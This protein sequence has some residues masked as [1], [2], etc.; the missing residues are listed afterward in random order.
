[1]LVNDSPVIALRSAAFGYADR[2]VVHD[3]SLT[4]RPGETI[5]IVGANG[6]GKSTL[7]KGLLGL[8]DQ[9]GG[10]V[11]LFGTPLASF[12]DRSL[13]GYVPQR[14]TLSTSVA[15]T[16]QEV[17]AIGRLPH[18][19]LLARLRPVDRQIIASSLEV[20]G[21]E[22]H[23]REEVS[24]LSGGQQ[25]RVLVARALA[26][27]PRVLVMDEPTA[28]V[29]LTN[30]RLLTD[31]IIGLRDQGVAQLIV[32]HEIDALRPALTRVVA[33]SGGT[34]TFDG[35][36]AAYDARA[37]ALLTGHDHHHDDDPDPH[38][39]ALGHRHLGLDEPLGRGGHRA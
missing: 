30:Q 10:S 34:V 33:M 22:G 38:A 39:H 31:V 15:S 9:L 8:N 14:H 23:A 3:V 16:V 11:E 37:V 13:V 17:V 32:T 36:L 1:M 20:V 5:A 21:L 12:K 35:S 25:R 27:E 7:V 24:T 4:V 26:A 2:V 6:C 28:G 29:D 19:G 18:Q